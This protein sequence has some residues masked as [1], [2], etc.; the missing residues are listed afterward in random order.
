M[1]G[2]HYFYKEIFVKF[3]YVCK[4]IRLTAVIGI[5]NKNAVAIAA[6]SAVTV[7]GNSGRKIYNTANKIFTLSK[8]HPVSVIVYNSANFITTPWEIIIKLYRNELKEKS[9]PSLQDY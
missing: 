6:D 3:N 8:Y 4:K 5:L 7:S 1:Y 9:F 2:S